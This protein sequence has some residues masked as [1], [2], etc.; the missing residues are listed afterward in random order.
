MEA[1]FERLLRFD[2][3]DAHGSLILEG[4]PNI[5]LQMCLGHT[6][7]LMVNWHD[8]D[9]DE[10]WLIKSQEGS[11]TIRVRDAEYPASHFVDPPIAIV[12][13]RRFFEAG[14]KCPELSWA[15]IE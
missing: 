9:M 4:P 14:A 11:G 12:A 3:T 15:T 1:L 6:G 2:L 7:Q 5:Q 8:W 13:L 10:D